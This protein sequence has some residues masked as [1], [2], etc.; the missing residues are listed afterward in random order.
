[1]TKSKAILYLICLQHI[2]NI[3]EDT[4]E[5]EK[6]LSELREKRDFVLLNGVAFAVKSKPEIRNME[7]SL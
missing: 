1:M 6:K 2:I 7:V 4:K 3:L 5:D